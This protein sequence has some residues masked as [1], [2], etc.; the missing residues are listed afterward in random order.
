MHRSLW[1]GN[2]SRFLSE[3]LLGTRSNRR[4]EIM[5]T[6]LGDG[7]EGESMDTVA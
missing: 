2:E 4:G 5:C 7:V 1:E 6:G 3:D